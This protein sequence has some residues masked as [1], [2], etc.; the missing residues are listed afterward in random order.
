MFPVTKVPGHRVYLAVEALGSC[1]F[2]VRGEQRVPQPGA[3]FPSRKWGARAH[4]VSGFLNL[5]T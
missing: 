3:E 4:S 5:T 2:N 1:S